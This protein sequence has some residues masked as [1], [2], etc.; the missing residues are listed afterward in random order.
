MVNIIVRNAIPKQSQCFS[1]YKLS[2]LSQRLS[3]V[4]MAESIC[5]V[6]LG[7]P[8]H[9]PNHPHIGPDVQIHDHFVTDGN[10]NKDYM[11]QWTSVAEQKHW[12][13]V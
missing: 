3:K 2:T 6:S 5:Y 7:E 8:S 13:Q 12:K 4:E 10:S 11:R 1:D 9:V